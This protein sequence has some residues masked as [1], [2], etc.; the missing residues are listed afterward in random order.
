MPLLAMGWN[1]NPSRN[2]ILCHAGF[3]SFS[4][5]A[6]SRF[7][8]RGYLHAKPF[9]CLEHRVSNEVGTPTSNHLASLIKALQK[10]L[11]HEKDDR[12]LASCSSHIPSPAFLLLLCFSTFHP[13]V[14]RAY[15][16]FPIPRQNAVSTLLVSPQKHVHA[17]SDKR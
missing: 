13:P 7:Q 4:L 5:S 15:D 10:L 9:Q 2:R 8:R 6:W 16:S 3:S 12:F 11:V 14:Q 1:C 17:K